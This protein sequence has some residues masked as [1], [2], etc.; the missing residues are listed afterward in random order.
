M[1]RLQAALFVYT[2]SP[3]ERTQRHTPHTVHHLSTYSDK[4]TVPGNANSFVGREH[5]HLQPSEPLMYEICF[6]SQGCLALNRPGVVRYTMEKLKHVWREVCV[7]K[8]IMEQHVH[9]V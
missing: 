2:H 4:G 1:I 8:T 6:S 5:A 3:L 7:K 9:F